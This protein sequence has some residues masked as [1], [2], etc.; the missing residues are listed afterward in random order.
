MASENFDV[1]NTVEIIKDDDKWL[2]GC[3]KGKS[4][5]YGARYRLKYV[6]DQGIDNTNENMGIIKFTREWIRTSQCMFPSFRFSVEANKEGTLEERYI[7]A[8]NSNKPRSKYHGNDVWLS[9]VDFMGPI[10]DTSPRR[11]PYDYDSDEDMWSEYEC[12]KRRSGSSSCENGCC[13]SDL[14]AISE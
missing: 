6:V 4:D 8:F 11:D 7:K 5:V 1:E 3:V 14:N 9:L 10:L 12:Y 2:L 13:G